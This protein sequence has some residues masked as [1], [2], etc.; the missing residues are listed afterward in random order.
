VC[1]YR[2]LDPL[3]DSTSGY[4]VASAA[5][6]PAAAKRISGNMGFGG[7]EIESVVRMIR[8]VAM[9]LRAYILEPGM[10]HYGLCLAVLCC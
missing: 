3:H 4:E 7:K 2:K 1:A 6:R 10:V 8:A 9:R 5:G